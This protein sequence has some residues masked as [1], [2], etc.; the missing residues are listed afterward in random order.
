MPPGYVPETPAPEPPSSPIAPVQVAAVVPTSSPE[1][2]VYSPAPAQRATRPRRRQC[3]SHPIRRYIPR[4]LRS[5]RCRQRRRKR[6]RLTPPAYTPRQVRL[7][8]CRCR[9]RRRRATS[10]SI[11]PP[12]MADI[13]PPSRE[14][15][16]AAS[17]PW[18]LG[19]SGRGYD[20]TDP[21]HGRLWASPS[22]QRCR[23]WSAARPMVVSV[24]GAGRVRYRARVVGLAHDEAVN[25]CSRLSTG[26][27]GC[28]VL[29]PDAQS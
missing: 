24:Y 4:R 20:T 3:R 19:D 9:R 14:P 12:A 23:C 5:L 28:E 18:R 8:L 26:P 22:C 13:P 10:F 7:P 27:T 21:T 16:Y 6:V 17:G 11:I 25:A 1:S 15:Q 2:S 29:S